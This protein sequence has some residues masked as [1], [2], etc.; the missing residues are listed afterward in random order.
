VRIAPKTLLLVPIPRPLSL[1]EK[2]ARTASVYISSTLCGRGPR[3]GTHNILWM[4]GF[5]S[6]QIVCFWLVTL[7]R[8]LY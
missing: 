5:G 8:L 2:E 6:L 4:A 3:A 1:L 7:R